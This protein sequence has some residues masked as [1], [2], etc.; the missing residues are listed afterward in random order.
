VF[1]NTLDIA[2]ALA[3]TITSRDIARIMRIGIKS[4]GASCIYGIIRVQ[5]GNK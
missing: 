4:L 5:D 1:K 3:Q 2:S